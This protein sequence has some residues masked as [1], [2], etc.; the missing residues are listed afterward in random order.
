[1]LGADRPYDEV[2]YFWSDLADW[3]SLEYVGA[4]DRWEREVLRGSPDDGEFAILYLEGSRLVGALSVGRDDDLVHARR[5]IHERTELTGDPG[6]LA[7][8]DLAAL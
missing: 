1:M 4:A 7:T 3:S 8:A 2:P 5:L 6:A